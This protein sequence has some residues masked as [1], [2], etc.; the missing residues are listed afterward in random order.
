MAEDPH[1]SLDPRFDPA[2]QR[3]YQPRAGEFIRVERRPA[4]E[5]MKPAH[6]QQVSEPR[7]ST[8]PPQRGAEATTSPS[9]NVVHEESVHA[10]APEQAATVEDWGGDDATGDPRVTATPPRNPYIVALWIVG[11][12]SVVLGLVLYI[13][14]ATSGLATSSASTDQFQ[15]LIFQLGW[16]FATPLVTVGLLT[17]VGL[18]F[19]SAARPRTPR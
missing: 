11:V 1:E 3:G 15:M 19:L 16:V 8:Q 14:S 18:L 5:A 6:Q 4:P 17:I 10:T 12:G 7:Q 2:F 13:L 9:A